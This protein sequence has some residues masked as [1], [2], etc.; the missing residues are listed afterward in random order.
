[1]QDL[2]QGSIVKHLMQMAAFIAAG[3]LFQ[4]LYII[5]DLYFVSALGKE[6]I[7]GVG[8]AGNVMFI[9]MALTAGADHRP[10]HAH[11]ARGGPQGPGRRE[12]RVQSVDAAFGTLG[13][14][15]VV[16][17]T[18][19]TASYVASITADAATLPPGN[20]S[21]TGICRA[22]LSVR[23]RRA[24]GSALRGTGIV[25]PTMVVQ[26]PPSSEH[27][28]RADPDRGMGHRPSAR[29]LGAALATSISIA[30][31]S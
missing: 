1:M 13:V 15:V 30:S 10:R 11:C 18:G 6:A 5:V 22:S 23:D 24:S 31:A 4:T 14:A 8:A 26:S 17:D 9:V 7:A 27:H 12:S 2:T 29:R 3:M 20:L 21:A 19:V 25:K 16:G 28:S